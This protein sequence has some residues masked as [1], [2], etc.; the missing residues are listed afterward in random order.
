MVNYI[1][2]RYMAEKEVVISISV[3]RVLLLSQCLKKVVVNHSNVWYFE[4]PCLDF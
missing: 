1:E 3:A 4:I 2:E